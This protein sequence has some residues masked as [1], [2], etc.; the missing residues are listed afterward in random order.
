MDEEKGIFMDE[1]KAF[2]SEMVEDLSG[3]LS[4]LENLK[5]DDFNAESVS[6]LHTLIDRV[7]TIKQAIAETREIIKEFY[8]EASK[9]SS[10][11]KSDFKNGLS[12]F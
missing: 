9:P 8:E 2:R 3:I 5:T 10:P 1:E 12:R 6:L 4:Y 11:L 7:L